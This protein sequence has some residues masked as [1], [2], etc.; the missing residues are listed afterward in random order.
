VSDR[1]HK[2]TFSKHQTTI[3]FCHYTVVQRY[4]KE[5]DETVETEVERDF[6]RNPMKVAFADETCAR[7]RQML[8]GHEPAS[9]EATAPSHHREVAP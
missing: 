3:D 5:C 7:C 9:W 8:Y 6:I 4:C 2:H 1:A